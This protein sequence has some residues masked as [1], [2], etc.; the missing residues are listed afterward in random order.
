M[1]SKAFKKGL[2]PSV[3]PTKVQENLYYKNKKNAKAM[4]KCIKVKLRLNK[5]GGNDGT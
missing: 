5:E 1:Y 2:R 3:P 4:R